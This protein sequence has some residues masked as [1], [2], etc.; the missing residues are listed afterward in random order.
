[1][2]FTELLTLIFIT[3]KLLG[4]ISWNWWLVLLPEII[5]A[6]IYVI[7]LVVFVL[8][9]GKVFKKTKNTLTNDDFFKNTK[10]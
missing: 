5:A 3:L 6:V 10:F 4:V 1:M 9:F 8:I 7:Y 2:G